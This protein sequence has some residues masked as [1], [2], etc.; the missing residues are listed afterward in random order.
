MVDCVARH[1]SSIGIFLGPSLTNTQVLIANTIASDNGDFGIFGQPTASAN[2]TGVIDRVV[3][4]GNLGGIVIA[5]GGATASANFTVSNTIASNNA[6]LGL[7][8][9]TATN[10]TSSVD[11]DNS[12]FD[13]NG[14]PGADS[15]G[16]IATGPVVIRIARST[17]DQNGQFGVNNA[18][19]GAGAV[20]SAGDNHMD[21]DPSGKVAGAAL[22]A[23]G[24]N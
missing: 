16:V 2:V 18:T 17:L 9:Y 19:T 3:A 11:I 4:T 20:Y 13:N 7:K 21:G 15:A 12:H 6:D 8:L 22:V 10:S 14:P 24:A 5:G 1:F 23:D